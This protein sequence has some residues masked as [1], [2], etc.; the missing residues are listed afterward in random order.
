MI[1]SD[2]SQKKAQ[3]NL[4]RLG[5]N[6]TGYRAENSFFHR[7]NRQEKSTIAYIDFY[8]PL[9]MLG[10]AMQSNAIVRYQLFITFMLCYYCL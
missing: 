5:E 8:T 4:Q 2:E 6:M 3:F 10:T 9:I 1:S 7:W